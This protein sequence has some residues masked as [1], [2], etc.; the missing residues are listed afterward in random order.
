MGHRGAAFQADA[1]LVAHDAGAAVA[2]GEEVAADLLGGAGL[3]RTQRGG[4][5][6]GVL[7]EVLEGHAP[8]RVDQRMIED[9]GLQHR[10]DHHLADA[11]GGLARLGAVVPGEDLGTLFDNAGITEAVQLTARQR[12]DP[13]DI[14]VVLLRHRDGAQLVD[15]AEPAEQLHRAAVGDVHLGMPRGRGVA[16]DQQTADAE[17]RQDARQ[18][19]ADRPA[20]GDQYLCVMLSGAK[21][22]IAADAGLVEA[23]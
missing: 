10:L 18:G 22:L 14:E 12:R 1:E 2:A 4:H 5:A 3:D 7:L 8:A 21:H 23:P 16:L 20:A 9:G 15:Q 11:H 17:R 13:G 6:I 19:H